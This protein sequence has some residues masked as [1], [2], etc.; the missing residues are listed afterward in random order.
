[1]IPQRRQAAASASLSAM[2]ATVDERLAQTFVELADTLVAGY[3]LMEFLQTLTDRCVELLEVDAAGLLLADNRGALRLIAGRR[4]SGYLLAG[5][6]GAEF[7]D[8]A[9]QRGGEYHG[10]VL[11]DADLDQALQVPQLQCQ[12][13]GH[14]RV[15]RLPQRGGGQ[16]LAL[17]VDDLRPL[18]PLGLGLPGHGPF[19][20]VG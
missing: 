11:V 15:G 8:G 4:G 14:H 17:G 13:V 6:E 2:A 5:D 10:G 1:V 3:D 19:H 7:G 20:A 16:G 12:R 18:F 9:H